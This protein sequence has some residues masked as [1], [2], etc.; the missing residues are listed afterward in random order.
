MR[1]LAIASLYPLSHADNAGQARHVS[2][3]A[4][5]AQGHDIEVIRPQM[6]LYQWI[7]RD[8]RLKSGQ[9]V[10]LRYELDGVPVACPRFW[11]LPGRYWR[12]Y[13]A[14]WRYGPV[15]RLVRRAHTAKPFDVI[16][17]C[18]LVSDGVVAVRLGREM[19]LPVMLSSI[20]SDA[21]TYPYQSKRAMT[22]TRKVL[23]EAD[24]ILVEGAGAVEDIR[25]L[26]TH[27]A[28]I[29]VFSRGI[30]LSR[31]EGAL[32]KDA[33]REKHGL[34]RGRR[35]IVFVG[36][37]NESK[38][39]LVL[40]EAFAQIAP[41]HAD[42]DLVYVGSGTMF[43]DIRTMTATA[44]LSDRVHLLGKRPFSE[45]PHILLA[46]D[47]FCLP[48][49]AE[50]LPKSVVEG[51]AAGLPV[52]ATN[53]GGIPDVMSH[54]ECGILV[55]PRDVNG[56]AGALDRL[57]ANPDEAARMGSVGQAIARTHFD[58]VKN[59]AGILRFAEEA[60]ARGNTRMAQS[61]GSGWPAQSV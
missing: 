12:P 33:A 31:F 38:G 54:G 49:F 29:H 59:A 39:V 60:I 23:C 32:S 14:S 19:K 45:V 61:E 52:V 51:M 3:R 56:L 2:F 22:V 20:G 18:E 57:L 36:T 47:V 24:L 25:R 48:S 43:D 17:G 26:T 34:P 1:I 9:H 6:R 53:V 16:Y 40:A 46:C 42:A 37:L 21:H 5:V 58:T 50:G 11:R 35:L 55:S 15:A 30:D 10:P 13:E 8:W 44:G 41:R 28:P 4:L 27:T 7:S